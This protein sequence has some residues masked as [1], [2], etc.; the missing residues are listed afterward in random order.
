MPRHDSPD[1]IE[2]R[3]GIVNDVPEAARLFDDYRQFYGRSSDVAAARRFLEDRMSRN[4]STILLA[5]ATETV[6]GASETVV[7]FAQ[8]YPSFS[9]LSL[10]PAWI[11]ND[12]FIVPGYRGRGVGRRLVE[13]SAAEAFRAGA[14]SLA[15]ETEVTNATALAFYESMGFVRDNGFLHLTLSAE[16]Q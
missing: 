11:L 14:V 3:N 5:I 2:I 1:S 7:G 8:L 4:E 10:R 6:D 15:L 16:S 13:A 9:S 12:L